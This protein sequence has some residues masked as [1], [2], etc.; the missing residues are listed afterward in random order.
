MDIKKGEQFLL[1]F[2]I[3]LGDTP[4]TPENI[5]GLRI[6]VVNRLCEWPNG[7][8]TYGDE[9]GVWNYP[10]L[11]EQSLTFFEGPRKA[12]VAVRVGNTIL[13]TEVFPINVK[14]SIIMERWDDE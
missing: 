2:E 1:P 3:T 14:D 11:Q 9:N 7:E 5:D 6:K 12:Q 8:I 13:K 10:V 4:A